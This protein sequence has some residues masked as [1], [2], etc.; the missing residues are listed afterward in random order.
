MTTLVGVL[1]YR[2][3]LTGDNLTIARVVWLLVDLCLE[4]LSTLNVGMQQNAQT[5]S[6]ETK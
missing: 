2:L 4:A 1:Q 5:M 6:S 3:I